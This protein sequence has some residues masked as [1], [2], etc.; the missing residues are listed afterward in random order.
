MISTLLVVHSPLARVLISAALVACVAL[1]WWLLP[2]PG[3]RR[4]L[5]WLAVGSAAVLL[6][7]TLSPSVADPD[8]AWCTVQFAL[9]R[10]GSV[11][12][13]ANIAVFFPPA[14]FLTLA[15]RRP[16]A[17]VAAVVAG[18]GSVELVQAVLPALGRAC[19]TNDAAMNGVGGV[20]GVM[21]AVVVLRAR[22]RQMRRTVG[23]SS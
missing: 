3:S 19:D 20:L 22:E 5:A 6:A 2:R 8:R 17:A 1:G 10:L 7:L 4:W 11:E 15:W 18:T 13:L 23:G 14:F 16:L 9:P 12:A 21:V